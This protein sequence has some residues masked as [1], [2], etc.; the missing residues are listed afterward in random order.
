MSVPCIISV[1]V[2]CARPLSL[3]NCRMASDMSA[4]DS[5][6]VRRV[7]LF[8]DYSMFVSSLHINV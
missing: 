1:K 5:A 4:S 6:R 7:R 3:V 8:L 2:V